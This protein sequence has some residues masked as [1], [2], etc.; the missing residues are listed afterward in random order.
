MQMSG[1]PQIRPPDWS[2]SVDPLRRC[3]PK[4]KEQE[5]EGESGAPSGAAMKGRRREKQL[6]GSRDHVVASGRGANGGQLCV[7]HLVRHVTASIDQSVG[8]VT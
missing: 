1:Q 6:D 5:V 2:S 4:K 3:P 7:S 8:I